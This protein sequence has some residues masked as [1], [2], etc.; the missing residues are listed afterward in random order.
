MYR[1]TKI[2]NISRLAVFL[3]VAV[4]AWFSPVP[5]LAQNI[6]L[7]PNFSAGVQGWTG[8]TDT[9]CAGGVPSI[10]GWQA[11]ALNFSYISNTVTQTVVVPQPSTVTF[12]YTA[13]IRPEDWSRGN[14]SVSLSS[15]SQSMS[16]GLFQPTQIP[17]E[18]ALAITTTSPNESVTISITGSDDGRFWAGCYGTIV[19]N[20]GLF[21]LPTT[22]PVPS[23][24]VW[25]E[26]NEGWSQTISAPEGSVF[27]D[28]LF[29]SY[30]N[31]E[32]QNGQYTQGWCH[33]QSSEQIVSSIVLGQNSAELQASNG[34]FGDPCGGTYKRLYVLLKYSEPPAPTTTSTSTTSTTTTSTSTT[35]TT[36]TTVPLTAPPTVPETTVEPTTTTS[37]STTTTS[38]PRTT[39]TTQVV[40]TSAPAQTTIPEPAPV[41][42]DEKET[43]QAAPEE[44]KPFEE[45]NQQEIIAAVEKLV[46]DGVTEE[47]AAELA[48]NPQV[49][50]SLT[51]EQAAEV[52]EALD[53]EELTDEQIEQLVAAVQNAPDTVRK[54]FEDKVNVFG[55]QLDTY[56]PTGSA[57]SVAERRVV[58]AAAAAL[59]AAPVAATTR[60]G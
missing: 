11:N 31:P 9:N 54:E 35:S 56:V 30:G 1:R 44:I 33:A 51:E 55:G 34:V 26:I 3:P 38:V 20:A 49:V 5:A 22:A 12:S 7:N 21:A 60:K 48:T 18:Y 13:Q 10:G 2:W 58:V 42:E 25:A 6:L 53:V 57:I 14:L 16:S 8:Q 27:T 59:A 41:P 23:N 15:S 39:T 28:V 52:F 32:G 4:L 24:S 45:M 19:T 40:T 43:T 47:Q 37:S 46:E 29:A 50:A 36:T 17:T